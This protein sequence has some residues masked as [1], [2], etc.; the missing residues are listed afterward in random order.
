M[1]LSPRIRQLSRSPGV[2]RG[3]APLRRLR[4]RVEVG[5]EAGEVTVRGGVD[6]QPRGWPALGASVLWFEGRIERE[7]EES[8][9]EEVHGRKSAPIRYL[10][11][12]AELTTSV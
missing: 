10:P 5:S 4:R 11:P 6:A 9:D 3:G 1:V 8:K 7:D 12:L 2:P